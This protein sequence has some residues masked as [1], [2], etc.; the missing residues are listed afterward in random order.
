MSDRVL[1]LTH[2]KVERGARPDESAPCP[3][4]NSTLTQRQA[5]RQTCGQRDRH[6][7]E[8][9]SWQTKTMSDFSFAECKTVNM[10]QRTGHN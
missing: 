5:D 2:H 9:C 1:N 3:T 10:L 6:M 7:G 8:D 4:N